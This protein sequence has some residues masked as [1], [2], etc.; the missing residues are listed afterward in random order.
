MKSRE[1]AK[2]IIQNQQDEFVLAD[3][4][5]S[6]FTN[7]REDDWEYYLNYR[8]DQG[9]NTIYVNLLQQWDAS[10]SKL[11][12]HPFEVT[13]GE[14]NFSKR[15]EAYFDRVERMISMAHE[16]GITIGL[17]LLWVNYLPNTWA[18]KIRKMP[19]FPKNRVA[20]Y[21]E[22]AVNRY[23]KYH[24]FYIVS[25]DTDFPDDEVIDYYDIAMKK[26]KSLDKN[27]IVT[28]H[29]RGR[30]SDLPD[31]LKNSPYLDFYMYQSGHNTQYRD[32]AYKLAEIF[33]SMDPQKPVMNA[34]PCYEMMGFS[35]NVYGRFTRED[36]RKAAWQS[37]FSGA[38]LGITYGAHG[39]WSWHDATAVFDST[40]G[41]AFSTPY[42]WHDALRFEGA[43]D[44]AYLKEFV[45]LNHLSEG[46][47]NQKILN[48]HSSEIR[49]LQ[50]DERYYIYVPSNIEL[51]LNGDF[52]NREF[53]YLDLVEKKQ[54]YVSAKFYQESNITKV[55]MHRF[56]SD[57]VLIIN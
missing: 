6:A 22:Y 53:V 42:D 43:N 11:D 12:I 25:G 32:Y 41:E 21:V 28:L 56:I 18:S 29:I 19:I 5:W 20:E 52:S 24:P 2:K 17:V 45:Q 16:R 54:Q 10:S 26:I 39:I 30:E 7:I 3:T 49:V 34:E 38:T 9:F 14:F 57:A 8:K 1:L 35:R 47:S 13:D 44:Y 46:V 31:K 37:V 48:N 36:V 50:K 23:N 15:N 40:I 4:C 55:N 33:T 27:A 51:N